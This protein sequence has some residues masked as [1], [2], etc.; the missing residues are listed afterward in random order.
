[1]SPTSYQAALPRHHFFNYKTF[2]LKNLLFHFK[3]RLEAIHLSKL[4]KHGKIYGCNAIYSTNPDDVDVLGGVDQGI[5][6]EMYHSGIC[7]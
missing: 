2:L 6:H 1:M 5:M 3:L 7:E 4:K